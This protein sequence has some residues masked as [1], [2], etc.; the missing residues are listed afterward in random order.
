VPVG[1]PRTG[2]PNIVR[3]GPRQRRAVRICGPDQSQKSGHDDLADLPLN[4][5]S[6]ALSGVQ[7]RLPL[8]SANATE[9][10]V[11]SAPISSPQRTEHTLAVVEC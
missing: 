2:E 9:R 10:P 6:G 8:P 5:G 1:A 4:A 7:R 3:R 11:V